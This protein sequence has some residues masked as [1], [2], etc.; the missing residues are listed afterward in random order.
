MSRGAKITLVIFVILFVIAG[1]LVGAWFVFKN[2]RASAAESY[3]LQGDN[4]LNQENFAEALI[5][6]KKASLLTPRS[7]APYLKQG[8]LAKETANYKEAI[9][10]IKHSINFGKQEA[11]AYLVLG[12]TYLLDND[13]QN[14]E[15]AFK[16]AKQIVP[17]SDEIDFLLFKL[18]LKNND[19]DEAQKNLSAAQKNNDLPKYKIYEA[20]LESFSDPSKS[21]T[22][23]SEINQCADINSLS[24]NDFSNLFQK[25]VSTE[26]ITS[27]EIMIYETFSQI[28]EVDFGIM[29][30]ESI[31]KENP[32]IRDAWVFLSYSYLL[33]NEPD[34]AKITLDKALNLD[35]V[36]PATHYLLS[37][38]YEAK[39]NT[40]EA[41][42][43]YE[44]AKELGFDENNPLKS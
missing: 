20:L 10:F 28:G 3:I 18:S 39:Q 41:Q 34:K 29:G 23:I 33:K 25:L 35:P 24:L 32:D 14:A 38:Y 22:I 37:K 13:I 4:Y 15:I 30:L 44:R 36:Y 27:R 9:D 1:L 43:A 12:E 7:Y 19:L 40:N 21:M 2:E 16:Q 5:A 6:Y 26:N 17:S 31:T 11:G 42:K 8:L